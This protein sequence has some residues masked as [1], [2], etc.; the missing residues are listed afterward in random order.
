L[1]F[2]WLDDSN[3]YVANL[4]TLND[5]VELQQIKSGIATT[6]ASAPVNLENHTWYTL[7]VQVFGTRIDVYLG[8]E[9]LISV[10]DPEIWHSGTLGL[11]TNWSRAYF[12]D[13]R[14]VVITEPA[15]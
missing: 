10:D 11:W 13:M 3:Y 2:R 6:I 5:Q 4:H 12:D 7:T 9:R 8:C 1:L 15:S 14:A